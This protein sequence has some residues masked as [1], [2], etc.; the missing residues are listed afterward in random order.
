[1]ERNLIDE[2]HLLLTTIAVGKGKHLFEEIDDAP[3]LRLI[4]A[5]RFESGVLRLIYT[6]KARR[7]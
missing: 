2:F 7:G 1:M 4:D 3:Q 6:P 5:R